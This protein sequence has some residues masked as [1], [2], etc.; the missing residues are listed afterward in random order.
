MSTSSRKSILFAAL[1]GLGLAAF[2]G[3]TANAAQCR[4]DDGKFVKCKPAAEAATKC[5]N[6]KTKK[7]AKCGA[8]GTE[9]VPKAN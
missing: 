9:P 6:I 4:G 5:R 3:A 1:L 2:G 8:A 7:F